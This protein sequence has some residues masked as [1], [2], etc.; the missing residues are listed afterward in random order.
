M[1]N[2]ILIAPELGR[3]LT[4]VRRVSPHSHASVPV[5]WVLSGQW[6]SHLLYPQ[7]SMESICEPEA[8]A[9]ICFP[10]T[11]AFTSLPAIVSPTLHLHFPKRPVRL[12]TPEHSKLLE[13]LR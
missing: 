10:T 11:A 13:L 4:L 12:Q 5:S 8:G 9:N 1:R 2:Q 6:L 3:A 7:N